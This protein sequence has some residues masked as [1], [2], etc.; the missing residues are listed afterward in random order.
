MHKLTADQ[1]RNLLSSTRDAL[2]SLTSCLA[3]E[4]PNET[5]ILRRVMGEL[6]NASLVRRSPEL[7]QRQADLLQ[8]CEEAVRTH[9][10]R[11]QRTIPRGSFTPAPEAPPQWVRMGDTLIS[12]ER[13]MSE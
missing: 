6:Q 3:H 9:D 11:Y 7:T 12:W 10:D 8:R 1:F 2:A 13:M 5:R 4:V